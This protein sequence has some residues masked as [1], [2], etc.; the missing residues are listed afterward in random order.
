VFGYLCLCHVQ[1]EDE[2]EFF[3]N[4]WLSLVKT[5]TMFVGEIEF[6]DIPIGERGLRRNL[7]TV[8]AV[9]CL[10]RVTFMYF[11]IVGKKS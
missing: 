10:K 8:L 1:K 2:Y 3:N 5:G 11:N 9:G 7:N 4:P 6:S